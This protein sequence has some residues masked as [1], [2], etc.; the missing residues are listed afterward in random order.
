MEFTTTKATNLSREQLQKAVSVRVNLDVSL[1][2]KFTSLIVYIPCKAKQLAKK[3]R[4]TFQEVCATDVIPGTLLTEAGMRKTVKT[5]RNGFKVVSVYVKDGNGGFVK[6]RCFARIS[7]WFPHDRLMVVME[8]LN[9]RLRKCHPL[10]RDFDAEGAIAQDPYRVID[11][12]ATDFRNLEIKTTTGGV[13]S[14]NVVPTPQDVV[15]KYVPF[16]FNELKKP[17]QME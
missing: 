6:V 12:K 1:G 3:T 7:A 16:G 2:M 9:D 14:V 17:I 15:D 8:E 11:M 13:M 5:T 4:G 10:T